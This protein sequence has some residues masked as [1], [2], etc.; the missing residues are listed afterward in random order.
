MA[1][2]KCRECGKQVSTRAAACPSCGAPVKAKKNSLARSGCGCLILI[3]I[4]MAVSS[5]V[6]PFGSAPDPPVAP[7]TAEQEAQVA[8]PPVEAGSQPEGNS[9]TP[10]VEIVNVRLVPFRTPNG[11]RTQKVLID[12][13]NTGTTTVRAVDADIIP[14]GPKGNR[15][16]NA[17]HDYCIYAVLDS[18]PGIAPRDTYRTPE[19]E[20]HVLRPGYV[21]PV[22]VEVNVTEVVERGAF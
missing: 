3:L 11:E 8:A 16:G 21:K 2:K 13:K 10:S 7:L 14:F 4:L 22:K 5:G 6:I 1:L 9:G 17:V 20:G 18:K 19:S 12:F 15:L